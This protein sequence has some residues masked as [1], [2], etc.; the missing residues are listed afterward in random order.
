MV[1]VGAGGHAGPGRGG[2]DRQQQ[3]GIFTAP[4]DHNYRNNGNGSNGSDQ[5]GVAGRVW[6]ILHAG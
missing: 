2:R 1:V 5:V 3:N 4:M 6:A